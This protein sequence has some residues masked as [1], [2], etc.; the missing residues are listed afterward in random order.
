MFL[1]NSTRTLLSSRGAEPGQTPSEADRSTANPRPVRH[2][3]RGNAITASPIAMVNSQRLADGRR[4]AE[5]QRVA[6]TTSAP[7]LPAH[8]GRDKAGTANWALDWPS[9]RPTPDKWASQEPL[10][11]AEARAIGPGSPSSC[12]NAGRGRVQS[13][14]NA[15][16][17]RRISHHDQRGARKKAEPTP[18]RN[19][20]QVVE[21]RGVRYRTA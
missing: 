1:A 12:S 19:G 3:R 21:P 2:Q 20:E 15:A 16:Q 9:R 8:G 17:R 13:H 14:S 10:Q 6:S 7:A 18:R 5:P 4:N 11:A